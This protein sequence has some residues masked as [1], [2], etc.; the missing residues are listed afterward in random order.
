M[1]FPKHFING[2]KLLFTL[3]LLLLVF[4]SVDLSKISS[5]LRSFN[6]RSLILLL[7][8]CWVG[9]FFCSERWRLFAASLQMRGSYRS[10]VQMYFVGMFFNIGLPSL[11]GGD[12]V[13]AY[14]LSRKNG[15]PLHLGLATVLQDRAAGLISLFV[16]GTL[17]ILLH[18]ISWAGFPLWI[19]YSCFWVALAGFVWLV[20]RGEKIY[21]RLLVPESRTLLQK[22]LSII[23]EFHQALGISQIRKKDILRIVLYSFINSGL[24]LWAFQQVT[25]SAGHGVGIIPFSALF[26]I[27]TVATML[28][29][30]LGGLGVRE[31]FYVEALSMVGIPRGSGL[32]IS[33]ATSALLILCNLA[34]LLFLPG[35]PVELRPKACDLSK[36]SVQS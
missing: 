32:V 14:I 9:Q 22:L 12:V 3:L 19:V 31:W 10:F 16:Y 1:K 17:A 15:K 35:I 36:E 34:G 23:A 7:A 18:P 5:D 2:F 20:V 8:V 13:K 33:L 24:I 30:T 4:R 28:P 11:V 27:V 26:P 29:I 6:A 21:S 25:H